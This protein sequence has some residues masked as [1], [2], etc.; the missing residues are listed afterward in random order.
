MFTGLIEAVC[1]VEWVSARGGNSIRLVID[2]G[3]LAAEAKIGDSI[4][5][6]GVC[7]TIAGL[8]ASRA[9]FDVSG[10]TL[11]KSTLGGLRPS[12]VVNVERALM[13]GDRLGGHIVQGHVDGVGAV[14]AVRRQ[15]EFADIEY[16]AGTDLLDQMVVKGSVAVDGISLTVAGIGRDV[17]SVA[18]VPQTL[19][20]TTLGRARAGDSVNIETDIIVKFVKKQLESILPPKQE[21]T[22]E[23]LRQLGF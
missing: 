3:D 17:F 18:V 12:S 9:R 8:E 14:K 7:L 2:L 19:G 1:S 16:T 23:K 6:N 11:T 21:L 10:E 15:G 4:A 22:V 13:A 5:V 20:R